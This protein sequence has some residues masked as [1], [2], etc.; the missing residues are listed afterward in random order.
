[1]LVPLGTVL[2]VWL[3]GLG[4]ES[5]FFGQLPSAH[6]GDAKLKFEIYQDKAKEYRWRLKA[7]D[8]KTLATP[9]H[10][11]ETK[12]ECR[13]NIDLIIKELDKQKF[14]VYE[15]KAKEF[16]WRLKTPDGK[17]LAISNGGYDTKAE[18]QKAV[19]VVKKGV[20]KAEVSDA[21]AK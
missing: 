7:A 12:A 8:D 2:L 9:G 6:A 5:P 11:Y 21:K 15:D 3:A 18:C 13:K 4:S 19:D 10:G 20:K 14:E 17:L 1:M 16:R